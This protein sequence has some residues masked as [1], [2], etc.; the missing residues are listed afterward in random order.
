[1]SQRAF[2]L[3][4]TYR[5]E[6]DRPVVHLYGKLDT[7][8]SCLIRDTRQTPF[9]Y[10]EA[11]HAQSASELGAPS[12]RA[13]DRVTWTGTPVVRVEVA[14]PSDT[15]PLRERLRGEGIPSYEADVRFAMRYLIDRG[16]R[17]TL[18]LSGPSRPADG[19]DQ[20]FLNPEVVPAY[21]TPRLQVLS[22]DIETDPT[23]TRLLSIALFGCGASEVLLLTPEGYEAPNAA[24]PFATERDLLVTFCQRVR[25]IDP[26]V[27]TGWNVIDFDMAVLERLA[28]KLGVPLLLGR[29]PGLVRR[30]TAARG[31]GNTQLS[32]PG[33][34]VLDGIQLLRGAFI[35]L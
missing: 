17:G 10:V 2:I 28:K 34:V 14:K 9:F 8:E 24:Q 15:P 32:I 27:L 19:I 4:P 3:Q 25:E 30:R 12:T 21:W 1:M 16:I 5:F 29:G 18:A 13:S 35:R 33:R 31:R 26:D 23:A 11:H 20:V 6:A 7:G 22:F